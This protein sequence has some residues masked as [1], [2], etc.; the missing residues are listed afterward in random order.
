MLYFDAQVVEKTN[1]LSLTLKEPNQLAF[2]NDNPIWQELKE[3]LLKLGM[4]H[5]VTVNYSKDRIDLNTFDTLIHYLGEKQLACH[6]KIQGETQADIPCNE[7]LDNY[8]RYAMRK[9]YYNPETLKSIGELFDTP[10]KPS[11]KVRRAKQLLNRGIRLHT[12][13]QHQYQHQHHKEHGVQ[14]EKQ[15]EQQAQKQQAQNRQNQIQQQQQRMQGLQHQSEDVDVGTLGKLIHVGNLHELVDESLSLESLK[16]IWTDLV[17]AHAARVE[18][19]QNRITHVPESTLRLIIKHKEQFSYGVQLDDLPHGFGFTVHQHNEKEAPLSI[20]YFDKKLKKKKRVD[21]FLAPRLEEDNPP[22][23][24]FGD[25]GQF[26]PFFDEQIVKN[27]EDYAAFIKQHELAF[28]EV[29]FPKKSTKTSTRLASFI[30]LMILDNPALTAESLQMHLKDFSEANLDGL[31]T[32]LLEKGSSGVLLLLSK[33]RQL[34]QANQYE[35]FKQYFMDTSTDWRALLETQTSRK[36]ELNALEAIDY[37]CTMPAEERIWWNTMMD[38]H[39]KANTKTNVIDLVNAHRYF[40]AQLKA[41]EPPVVLPAECPLTKISNMK[42]AY[43]R[44]LFLLNKAI[45]PQEQANYLS[46]LDFSMQGFICA[47]RKAPYVL[48]T[49][50]MDITPECN[51]FDWNKYREYAPTVPKDAKIMHDGH[52]SYYMKYAF[53][54]CN[55]IKMSTDPAQCDIKKLLSSHEYNDAIILFNSELFYA[56]HETYNIKKI[57]VTNSNQ[58]HYEQLKQCFTHFTG[59]FSHAQEKEYL[60]ITSLI[61][62]RPYSWSKNE[63]WT[64]GVLPNFKP[65]YDKNRDYTIPDEQGFAAP[66]Y[67]FNNMHHVYRSE[68]DYYAFLTRDEEGYLVQVLQQIYN[69]KRGDTPVEDGGHIKIKRIDDPQAQDEAILSNIH[70]LGYVPPTTNFLYLIELS[71]KCQYFG[72]LIKYFYRAIGAELF[73]FPFATYQALIGQLNTAALSKDKSDLVALQKSLLPLLVILST[74][75]RALKE[76]R[77]ILSDWDKLLTHIADSKNIVNKK[78]LQD[79]V[80]RLLITEP[81]PTLFEFTCLLRLTHDIELIKKILED[82]VDQYGELVYQLINNLAQFNEQPDAKELA[83]FLTFMRTC[84]EQQRQTTSLLGSIIRKEDWPLLSGLEQEVEHI[85][86]TEVKTHLNA[87]IGKINF[88]DA[89]PASF[90]QVNELIKQLAKIPQE[91]KE[92]YISTLGLMKQCLPTI[93]FQDADVSNTL[94]FFINRLVPFAE[95]LKD[96]ANDL[97]ESIDELDSILKD[98]LASLDLSSIPLVTPEIIASC[99]DSLI[100]SAKEFLENLTTQIDKLSTLLNEISAEGEPDT[101]KLKEVFKKIQ[102]LVTLL[103]DPLKELD[104]GIATLV[105]RPMLNKLVVEPAKKKVLQSISEHVM[106][107]LRLQL[108]ES[109]SQLKINDAVLDQAGEEKTSLSGVFNEFMLAGLPQLSG[110]EIAKEIN[111]AFKAYDESNLFLKSVHRLPKRGK[112][113]ELLALL[114]RQGYFT[115]GKSEPSLSDFRELFKSFRRCEGI[116]L[117]MSFKV[118]LQAHQDKVALNHI[119]GLVQQLTHHVQVLTNAQFQTLLSLGLSDS[120]KRT[121][122]SQLL[123]VQNILHQNNSP[124]SQQA[125]SALLHLTSA[126]NNEKIKTVLHACKNLLEGNDIEVIS[127]YVVQALK[128]GEENN[129]AHLAKMLKKPE[130]TQ[131]TRAYMVTILNA[132]CWSRAEEHK[133][134]IIRQEQLVHKLI[135]QPGLK[136]LAEFYK[137]RPSPAFSALEAAVNDKD[138]NLET[139]LHQYELDPFGKRKSIS[140]QFELRGLDTFISE[141]KELRHGKALKGEV[142]K[143]LGEAASYLLAIADKYCLPIGNQLKPLCE[144]S[145]EELNRHYQECINRVRANP[146]DFKSKIEGLAIFCE[147][148]FRTTGK[149]PY[150]SQIVSVLTTLLSQD[151]MLLQ[152]QTGQGKSTTLAL[153]AAMNHSFGEEGVVTNVLSRNRILTQRDFEESHDFFAYLNIPVSFVTSESDKNHYEKPGILYSTTS[154]KSLYDSRLKMVN[155]VEPPNN[156]VAICDEVDAELFDN[157]NAFNFSD[158]DEDPYFNPLEWVYPLANEFIE[159]AE[160]TNEGI[161][162]EEDIRLFRNYVK[163][164]APQ[165]YQQ[166]SVRLS[167]AKL[168]Q[169]LDGACAASQLTENID[170]IIRQKTR[171]VHGITETI[172][173]AHLLVNHIE[174]KEATLS[175]G[176]QQALHARLNKDH[177][178]EVG[179]YKNTKGKEGLPPF[180]CDNVIECVDSQNSYSVL[181]SFKRLIGATGTAGTQAELDE[182]AKTLNITTLLD[183][184][185]RRKSKLAY[186]PTVFGDDET[187]FFFGKQTQLHAIKRTLKKATHQPV[188]IA[189]ANIDKATEFAAALEQKFPGKVQVIHAMNAD[190]PQI[191]EALVSQAKEPGQIT[192]VTPLAG[193]GVD[194]KTKKAREAQATKLER[195]AEQLLVIETHLDRYRNRRQLQGRSARDEKAGQTVGIFDL[196]EI[197]QQ[198]GCDL[199]PLSKKDKLKAMEALMAKMDNEACLERQISSKVGSFIN[200]YEKV[201]D[202]WIKT[203]HSNSVLLEELVGAKAAF[204]ARAELAWN[205]CLAE[206]DPEGCY[207]NPYIRYTKEGELARKALD[208]LVED[209][210]STLKTVHFPAC[211]GLISVELEAPEEIT[212][213]YEYTPSEESSAQPEQVSPEPAHTQSQ[214]QAYLNFNQD[215]SKAEHSNHQKYVDTLKYKKQFDQQVNHWITDNPKVTSSVKEVAQTQQTSVLKHLQ[216][217]G[218]VLSFPVAM[219]HSLTEATGESKKL[220]KSTSQLLSFYAAALYDLELEEPD[221][222]TLCGDVVQFLN[223]ALRLEVNNSKDQARLLSLSEDI[224]A[225]HQKECIVRLLD[226]HHVVSKLLSVAEQDIKSDSTKEYLAQIKQVVNALVFK[227]NASETPKNTASRPEDDFKIMALE[228]KQFLQH[229]VVRMGSPSYARLHLF[230]KSKSTKIEAFLSQYCSEEALNKFVKKHPTQSALELFQGFINQGNGLETLLAQKTIRDKAIGKTKSFNEFKRLTRRLEQEFSLNTSQTASHYLARLEQIANNLERRKNKAG[231]LT[232]VSL[233]DQKIEHLNGYIKKVKDLIKKKDTMKVADIESEIRLI[234]HYVENDRALYRSTARFFGFKRNVSLVREVKEVRKEFLKKSNT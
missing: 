92:A 135:G 40:F 128:A 54:K 215:L 89:H 103:E 34:K 9:K 125:F 220:T 232:N 219:L 93:K 73:A 143:Q 5:S 22:Y 152:I 137:T 85:K 208:K 190:D 201:F 176:V 129:L 169:L 88:N 46:K 166:Y 115:G 64:F 101:K 48:I 194:I 106:D 142:Q 15:K 182:A 81:K 134:S 4:G 53:N 179:R 230:S 71:Q 233:Y 41:M 178:E 102:S 193:R 127:Q 180:S 231:L 139:W 66:P 126:E 94:L 6:V 3:I 105:L 153:M 191:F 212:A 216:S 204:I 130:L 123:E 198:H 218:E 188:M 118:I 217:K 177:L 112:R 195:L 96:M 28:K 136:S 55:L 207:E 98:S 24:E 158:S 56:N 155:H 70:K 227:T 83:S 17:G 199:K 141:I 107:P 213:A 25:V 185:P 183:I 187:S 223:K 7:L 11:G 175:H 200:E 196:E 47:V 171:E 58:T 36:E 109:V 120:N 117:D 60:L 21:T 65:G 26:Y 159:R 84:S 1:H 108:T 23:T 228:V 32:I 30:Q 114:Y 156:Q 80:S 170:F 211:K 138:F 61:G 52:P 63:W 132:S 210:A 122:I 12:Q 82:N 38:Q 44:L 111:E 121:L 8:Y 226:L 39:V 160:F 90:K 19:P 113:D 154:D 174:D 72:S 205:E 78:F 173:E 133:T 224:K 33:L 27:Q 167:N 43:S 157:K 184:P 116:H 165:K 214:T 29:F 57:E 87:L 2:T 62:L 145:K 76:D 140:E 45:D 77:D 50:G 14:Q 104:F 149:Y 124:M 51:L 69:L 79:I 31:R 203:H 91:D 146:N 164:K 221:A 119:K 75:P 147:C 234:Q 186:L 161:F 151:N 42:T 20:L 16:V 209:F 49:Q 225:F 86:N 229:T 131:E 197:L 74:G 192:I 99:T 202:G 68:E 148:Y 163:D 37:L 181:K 172:S 162:E 59:D 168:S 10:S 95:Q 18:N 144:F 13:A 189:C 35:S 67:F 110:K 222:K 150:Q 97:K 206:S 100:K